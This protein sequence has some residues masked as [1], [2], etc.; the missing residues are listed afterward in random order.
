M[1]IKGT[2]GKYRITLVS[3]ELNEISPRGPD[4]FVVGSIDRV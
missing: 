2:D 4:T 1:D 3:E